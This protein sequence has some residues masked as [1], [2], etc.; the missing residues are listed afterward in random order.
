[1][2]KKTLYICVEIKHR[3][4]DSH[5]LLASKAVSAGYR[6]YIGT[7]AA[8]YALLKSKH[9]KAGILLDKSFQEITRMN[10]T[11]QFVESICILDPELS[12][13]IPS[14]QIESEV[15]ARVNKEAIGL[16]DKFFVTGLDMFNCCQ[17]VF[18]SNQDRVVY[19]GWPRI[20]M[21]EKYS[22]LIYHREVKNLKKKYGKFLLFASSFNDIDDP[23]RAINLRKSFMPFATPF[24]SFETRKLRFRNFL[25]AVDFLQSLER[26][27]TT[28]NIVLRPHPAEPVK[29]WRR[30]LGRGKKIRIV[31]KGEVTKWLL[32]SSG[33]LHN[34]STVSIQAHFNG[35]PAI[36]MSQVSDPLHTQTAR[37]VSPK[38]FEY[39]LNGLNFEELVS[40]NKDYRPQILEGLVG[41]IGFSPLTSMIKEFQSLACGLEERH[42]LL[43]LWKSQI[44]WKSARRSLGLTRDEIYWRIGVSNIHPQLRVVPWGIQKHEISRVLHAVTFDK[45]VKLVTFKS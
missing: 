29:V 6:V 41:P 1:M 32:A 11:K 26:N 28:P 4:L 7:H 15:Q 12:P 33:L 38:V 8:I 17:R 25:Q 10:W 36:Y 39:T 42:S 24:L 22:K 16:V 44:S 21:W 14:D 40:N 20:E 27:P 23:E 3:E 2:L 37:Q 19:S 45:K 9:S 34:G 13:A 31:S 35:V 30:A 5:V 43:A 18:E